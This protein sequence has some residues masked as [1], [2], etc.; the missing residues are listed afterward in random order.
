MH[1]RI[2]IC[3]LIGVL[4]GF[5]VEPA[6]TLP[7]DAQ[8]CLSLLNERKELE[9]AG[10]QRD[11]ALGP[12]WAKDNLPEER[13]QRI[14]RYIEVKE[15]LMFRCPNIVLTGP[16]ADHN[17]PTRNPRPGVDET[18]SDAN[19]D[20]ASNS[21]EKIPDKPIRKRSAPFGSSS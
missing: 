20:K 12:Q 16:G 13:L 10:A 4:G 7:M 8:T 5:L 9:N 15:G 19:S 17:L 6:L 14:L 3:A 11:M 1:L 21:G 2:W 18:K